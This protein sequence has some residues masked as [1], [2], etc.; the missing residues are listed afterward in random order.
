MGIEQ[1][2]TNVEV[3]GEAEGTGTEKQLNIV[4]SIHSLILI[5]CA[6]RCALRHSHMNPTTL[7]VRHSILMT[8]LGH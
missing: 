8:I 4:S 3:G 2:G 6:N 5:L 1:P 7:L